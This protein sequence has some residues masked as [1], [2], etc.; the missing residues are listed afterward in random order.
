[1]VKLWILYI[2]LVKFQVIEVL[3]YTVAH[4]YLLFINQLY[5]DSKIAHK[6]HY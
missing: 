4:S 2:L 6:D 3:L 1:M 5:H